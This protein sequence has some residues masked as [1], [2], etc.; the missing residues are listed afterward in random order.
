MVN[1][2]RSPGLDRRG[3]PSGLGT[4]E[5]PLVGDMVPMAAI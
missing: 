4:L 1:V 5:Q 2:T 3:S